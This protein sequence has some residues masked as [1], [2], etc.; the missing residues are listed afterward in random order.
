[1]DV[2]IRDLKSTDL[3]FIYSTWLRGVF[4]GNDFFN[5]VDK[6][7]FFDNYP[8]VLHKIIADK[9]TVVKIACLEDDD[10]VILGY[11]VGNPETKALHYAFVKDAWRKNRIATKLLS[12]ANIRLVTHLTKIGDVIRKKMEWKFNPWKI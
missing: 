11:I 12:N 6:E 2:R 3:N 10:D 7:A 5:Q 9:E 4:Y 1:L 8:A